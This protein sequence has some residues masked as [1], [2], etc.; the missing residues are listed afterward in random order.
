MIM[1][2]YKNL[3]SKA[4]WKTGVVESNPSDLDGVYVKKWNISASDKIATAGSC[5]AQ[6]ISKHLKK[7]NFS[8]ID[9]E[10]PPINMEEVE[11]S[12]NGYGLYSA[13]YGNIYTA[14]QLLQLA[15]EV[16]GSFTPSDM[17]WERNGRF[18]DSQRP[19][20]DAKGLE[21]ID[22]VLKSR[23]EH[24]DKVKVMFQTMDIFIFTLGLTEAWVRRDSG[25]VFP[26]VPGLIAGEFNDAVYE[27][28][29]YQFEEIR[30]AFNEFQ[31]IVRS[32]RNGR[33]F[34]IILTVSPVPLTATASGKHVLLS[35][36]YSKSV[37]RSIAGQLSN[38][39]PHID[40]FPSYEIIT[41]PSTR[42]NFY[43]DNLR[44]VK[45]CG[46]D[47]VMNTFFYQHNS[48]K[49]KVSP[50]KKP[51]S[52]EKIDSNCFQ[53]PISSVDI[54]CEEALLEAFNY[55]PNDKIAKRNKHKIV[56]IGD[57]HLA[58]ITNSVHKYFSQLKGAYDIYFIP[59]NWLASNWCNFSENKYL[60]SIKIK[61][62]YVDLIGNIPSE[63]DM[64]SGVTLCLVGL[65]MLGDGVIR[66][67]GNLLAG[68]DSLANGRGISPVM[69]QICS[70]E[71]ISEIINGNANLNE[72][73]QL[74]VYKDFYNE[75]YNFHKSNYKAL[76]ES[77]FY[78]KI[79]W[80]AGPNMTESVAR[81]RF[82]D[83]YVDSKNHIVHNQIAVNCFKDELINPIEDTGWLI[84]HPTNQD[85]TYGFTD[86]KFKANNVRYDI[87]TND[88][89]YKE[90][91]RLFFDF[92]KTKS[93][94]EKP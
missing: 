81:F 40:Y 48:E 25:M 63:D 69:P 45:D 90:S 85:T 17:V 15:S 72:I 18:Y 91:L 36:T 44:T 16:Q 37:L 52:L 64:R 51:L 83:E 3:P 54:Q 42:C 14:H 56:F 49:N 2:P 46:V 47:A 8:V 61:D 93:I 66:A 13:R 43:D 74:N 78:K 67:N 80:I 24:L 41:N 73:L 20:V 68:N 26:T 62:E 7:N 86:N 55:K 34:K 10:P 9:I 82:G 30:Q 29:N 1:N 11:Y 21:T 65:S 88:D 70:L 12:K 92:I 76:L 75:Y 22:A 59:T 6:H 38:N 27:F 32:I 53:S 77:K 58:G 94:R 50:L 31:E 23:N 57:S 89:F 28:K 87:H 79:V 35:S 5:F 4:F 19:G 84:T 33:F 71:R 60:T 39:Q